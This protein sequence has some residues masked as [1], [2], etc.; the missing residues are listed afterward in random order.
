MDKDN[1]L[2]EVAYLI[3]PAYSEEEARNFQQ[4]LK[5]HVQSFGGLI[6]HEGEILKRRLFYQIKKMA[7]AYLANFM[8]LL[9][10]DKIGDLTAKLNSK[11]IL[12]FLLVQTK[13]Q[14]ARTYRQRIAHLPGEQEKI[15]GLEKMPTVSTIKKVRG[16]EAPARIE[17]QKL[18]P[19]ANIEEIDKKLEEI[20]G[21]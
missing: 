15:S 21:K 8:F 1:Q 20:L 13:R 12:R 2:Y 9:A 5:N 19:A 10:P 7:E 3:S 4:S 11:E 6:D 18:E 16:P 14:P 17:P